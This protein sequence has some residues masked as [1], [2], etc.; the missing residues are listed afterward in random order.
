MLTLLETFVIFSA[1][2]I[3]RYFFITIED[4]ELNFD[5][6]I[7]RLKQDGSEVAQRIEEL[8]KKIDEINKKREEVVTNS[9]HDKFF[10]L[11]KEYKQLDEEMQEQQALDLAIKRTVKKMETEAK[12]Q[13]KK[14]IF[15]DCRKE[16]EKIAVEENICHECGS[17]QYVK[18]REFKRKSVNS[19]Y[20]F[21]VFV[22][23]DCGLLFNS[24]EIDVP[25]I[26]YV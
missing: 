4:K 15:D 25:E 14:K 5:E 24:R 16:V 22:C 26:P 23:E 20:S 9:K 18:A 2:V 1:F 12:I 19:P 21:V 6:R 3:M 11:T 7:E 8:Q 13:L 17:N 10:K